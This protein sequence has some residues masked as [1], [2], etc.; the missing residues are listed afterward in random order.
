MNFKSKLATAVASAAIIL[1]TVAPATFASTNVS[2][3]GALS[4]NTVIVSNT[5]LITIVQQNFSSIINNVISGANTGG[6][7]TGFNTGK[8]GTIILTGNATSNVTVVNTHSS[9]K[10]K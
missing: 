1:S 7:S 9:N 2:H 3:N 8:G 5:N 6:N 10:I 4:T